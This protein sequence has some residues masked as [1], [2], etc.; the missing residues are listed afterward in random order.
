MTAIPTLSDS[1]L[2]MNIWSSWKTERSNMS[3]RHPS[4]ARAMEHFNEPVIDM[5][6]VVRLVGWGQD[7]Y[8]CFY[9]YRAPFGKQYASSAVG[10]FIPLRQLKSQD[11]PDGIRHAMADPARDDF[12]QLDKWLEINGAPKAEAF[13][14]EESVWPMEDWE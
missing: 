4:Y 2:S 8:D 14:L 3:K 9:I 13:I 5:F 11:T 12:D 10:A 1:R 7:E 6:K